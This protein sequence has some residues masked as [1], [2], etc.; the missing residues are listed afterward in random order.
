VSIRYCNLG[1][2]RHRRNSLTQ[3]ACCTPLTFGISEKGCTEPLERC[4]KGINYGGD[5]KGTCTQSTFLFVVKM[6][7]VRPLN[8]LVLPLR[9]LLK[10][11]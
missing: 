6:Q 7:T 5:A 11:L 3:I 8:L 4:Q 10:V 1:K 2:V 9:M